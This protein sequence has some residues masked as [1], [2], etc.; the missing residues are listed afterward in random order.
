MEENGAA[1]REVPTAEVDA[2]LT[3]VEAE[4]GGAADDPP[5]LMQAKDKA[6]LVVVVSDR[7]AKDQGPLT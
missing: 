1:D 5:D 3:E 6:F 7:A 2:E 4:A